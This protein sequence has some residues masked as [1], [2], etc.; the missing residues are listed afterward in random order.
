[1]APNTKNHVQEVARTASLNLWHERLAHVNEYGIKEMVRRNIVE[2][3]S[4]DHPNRNI[5]TCEACVYGKV[6]VH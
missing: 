1:M 4:I 2:S 6:F 3:I 5:G